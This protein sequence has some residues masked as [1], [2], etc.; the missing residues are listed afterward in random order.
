MDQTL[1]HALLPLRTDHVTT[2][3]IESV[4]LL[5]REIAGDFTHGANDFFDERLSLPWL[6]GNKVSLAL[7]SYLD[8]GIAS[9]V[10]NALM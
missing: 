8:E 2:G 3:F 6:Q 7:S 4:N 5:G 1:L 9:H 10:L